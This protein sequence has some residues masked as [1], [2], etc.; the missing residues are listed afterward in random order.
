MDL[1]KKMVPHFTED[2]L[3]VLKHVHVNVPWKVLPQY[4]TM[5]LQVQMN[6][7]IGFEAEELDTVK[8]CDFR[9]VADDLHRHG[10]RITLHAPFWDL[11][12]GSTDR[13]IRHISRLRLQQF[14]DLVGVFQ[15]LQVVCHTGYDPRHHGSPQKPW[16]ERSLEVWEPLIRQAEK[17]NT[18]LL[19]ENVWEPGPELHSE[20]FERI[21]S[22]C[23]GFCL[24]VGHQHS[25]S[26]TPLLIWAESL[27][28][29]LM[30]IHVHDN[31]GTHDAHLPVGRGSIDFGTLF[32]ALEK[33]A[34]KPL[35]TLEPHREEHLTES[36]EGLR[37][38]LHAH[39]G[40]L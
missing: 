28:D 24:D 17:Q 8:R 27:L 9:V 35:L 39:E 37:R 32:S 16:I 2:M 23:F 19:L 26:E 7:E 29:F 12:T 33:G 38:V 10:C 13:L 20:M 40:V 25:F 31:D 1:L 30:E 18:P 6:V 4:L 14:L 22:P 5:I 15:P 21:D 11:C 3:N 34:R 36:L